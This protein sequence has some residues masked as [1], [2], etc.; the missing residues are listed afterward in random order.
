MSSKGT[1]S[2]PMFSLHLRKVLYVKDMDKFAE[3]AREV[4]QQGLD[5]LREILPDAE[6][7]EISVEAFRPGPGI[8]VVYEPRIPREKQQDVL[9]AMQRKGYRIR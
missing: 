8:D 1:V 2:I 3:E 9:R 4:A 6:L 5:D 7:L